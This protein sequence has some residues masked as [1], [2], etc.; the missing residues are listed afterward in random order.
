MD[1]GFTKPVFTGRPFHVI[2][3][4][5]DGTIRSVIGD[6]FPDGKVNFEKLQRLNEAEDILMSCW[7]FENRKTVSFYKSR[8]IG[9]QEL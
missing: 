8:I 4:K 3:E 9:F 2:F 7:D 5:K 6:M 1:E